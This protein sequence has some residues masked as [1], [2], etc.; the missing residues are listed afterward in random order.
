MRKVV[1]RSNGSPPVSTSRSLAGRARS[2]LARDLRAPSTWPAL[3]SLRGL[4]VVGVVCWH[5]SRLSAP[6]YATNAVPIFYWPLGLGR[7]GVDVFFVL[8]G[9]LV[10]RSWRSTRR[11]ASSTLR[12][13]ADFANRRARRI[14]PAYWCSLIVL[15]ALIARP[16]LHSPRHLLMFFTLNEYLRFSLPAQVNVVYWSLSVEWH[17]YLLVPLAAWLMTRL[18]RWWVLLG[19][20]F[21]S[22]MWWSHRP[23]MQLPQG[24]IFGHLDQFIAGAIV[25]ELV[26]AY[27]NGARP[28]I[29]RFGQRKVF[30]AAALLAMIA[31]GTYHGSTLGASRGNGFDPMLHPLFGLCAAGVI[32]HLLTTVGHAWLEHRALRFVGLISYSLY[33]WHFPILEHGI[34]WA[35]RLTW[36]PEAIWLP[37]VI[38]G[39][40][41]IAVAVAV[42]SYLLVERPFVVR[43]ESSKTA[44]ATA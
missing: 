15:L 4:A 1:D 39:F 42:I 9:F 22:F 14:L 24:S 34:P 8:S 2:T 11:R 5:V 31:I 26:I 43:K 19:C 35:R 38:V 44:L 30:G 10:I 33:L 21:L 27:A 32:L 29:V 20:L 16:V 3:D 23:P 13:V 12:A 6:H 17:F 18:G 25:G 40:V 28:A 7:L 41:A 37:V 36:L